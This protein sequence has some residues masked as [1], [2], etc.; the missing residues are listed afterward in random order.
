MTLTCKMAQHKMRII[1]LIWFDCWIPL[2]AKKILIQVRWER[3]TNNDIYIYLY[4]TKSS[5]TLGRKREEKVED[6][7]KWQNEEQ[8]CT[9]QC[10]VQFNDFKQKQ[11]NNNNK[12]ERCERR[13]S[14]TMDTNLWWINMCHIRHDGHT[15]RT[16]SHFIRSFQFIWDEYITLKESEK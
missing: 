14:L 13:W 5:I 10:C 1:I 15:R 6:E 3:W 16:L 7:D 11:D 2:L 8:S 12:N 9:F 4:D